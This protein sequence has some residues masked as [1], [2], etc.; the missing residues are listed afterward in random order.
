MIPENIVPAMPWLESQQPS[1]HHVDT[2][3]YRSSKESRPFTNFR[4]LVPGPN[5]KLR[6]GV[7]RSLDDA[8][9]EPDD[10]EMLE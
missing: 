6:P 8:L 3:A 4:R 7:C 9:E 5:D 2:V 1:S 10:A